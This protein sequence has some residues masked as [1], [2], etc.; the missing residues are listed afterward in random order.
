MASGKL[1]P[2]QKMINLMYLI[3]IAMLALNMSKEVL[4]AFG[5]MNEKLEASNNKTS[6]NNLAF[7][8]NLETKA[9]EDAAKYAELY[10]D[11]QKI[12]QLSKEYFDYLENLKEQMVKDTEDPTD[13][14]VMDKSDYL[15]QKLFQGDNLAP[16]GKEFM[17]R[18]TEYRSQV[19]A[20]LGDGFPQV[21]DVVNAR[22][23]TGDDN[24][25]VVRRDGVKIDWI[26]YHYEGFPLIASLTKLTSIQS[27]IKASEEAAL[28][29]MLQ[30]ELTSQVSL[31]NFSTLLES[32]K[33]AF[34]SGE[35]FQGSIVLGK[36]DKS[37]KPVRAELKLDG[38]NMTEGRDYQ[39]E[40]GGVKLLIGAGN[41]GDHN[42]SGILV[43]MQDG[44]E[45]EVPVKNTFSTISKPNAALIAA[46]KM[47]VVYRG[48]SNPMSITIP[49]IPNNKVSARAPGLSKRSGSSYVMNP[50]T[51]RSVTITATGTLPDGQAVSSRSE[52]RIKDIPRPAGAIRGE[53][54]STKMPRRNLE[55]STV[56]AMLE[57]FDFDLNLAIG[58]FKFKVPGQPTV[59]VKG[60]KLDSR[61][62]SALKRAKRGDAV[63]VFDINA[64]ITNNKS[65]KLKKV[66]PV[67]IEITN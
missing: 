41:P 13:Y 22:F 45:K 37:A 21:K 62:K 39:L 20:I 15:D 1:S 53:T 14:Q 58:G 59:V 56:S 50:G 18:I 49:G 30:G 33:S 32:E 61:A 10:K 4:A 47:N 55:I 48:V 7:F 34:Y 6:E 63:Q 46:D 51:G 28:K 52:F 11:A 54:G 5:L 57:D 29:A 35:R 36:T 26:N 65:Y 23:K 67:I 16:E 38:R 27:D 64:Y 43:Y 40:E 60:N 31:S 44:N 42:I 3:F 2:R 8:E 17:K 24:G 25:K 66:S 19:I 12:K 9:S